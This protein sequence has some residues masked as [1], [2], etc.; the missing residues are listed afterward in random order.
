[1]TKKEAKKPSTCRSCGQP[2]IWARSKKTDKPM[3]VDPD[4][5]PEGNVQLYRND[6]T[7]KVT[8]T[9]YSA[10]YAAGI[11][12]KAEAAGR[13]CTL[14]T[15]HFQTCPHADQHRKENK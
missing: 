12:A 15:S 3:P 14:R 5:S 8:F 7:G 13:P 1:M 4:P 6:E 10:E 11:R 2:I 9:S